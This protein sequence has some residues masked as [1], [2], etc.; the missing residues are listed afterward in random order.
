[1]RLGTRGS[2]L[3]RWQAEWVA[4]ELQK[5]GHAVE[6]VE[7]ATRGD[8]DQ[9][10]PIGDIGTLGVFT[11]AIQ[12][13]LVDGRVDLAVHSLKDL[14]TEPVTGLVL[15]AVPER[16][17]PAD[18]LVL[19]REL[20]ARSGGRENVLDYLPSGARV[21]TGAS[22]RCCWGPRARCAWRKAR[23]AGSSRDR[24]GWGWT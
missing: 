13:A 1:M 7:I 17:S 4:S 9:S 10:R 24:G 20:G 5:L 3:A 19:P 15:A 16:E 8:I 23:D 21:G 6:L 22:R 12:Q 2:Q 18:V 11:K 14:P